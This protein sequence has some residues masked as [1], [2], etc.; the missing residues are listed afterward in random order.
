MDIPEVDDFLL[1]AYVLHILLKVP[2]VFAPLLLPVHRV[3][4]R[5]VAAWRYLNINRNLCKVSS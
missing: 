2:L 4:R 1:V 5:V 3:E